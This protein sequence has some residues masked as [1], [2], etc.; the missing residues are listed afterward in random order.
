MIQELLEL[1]PL[2]HDL[3]C[4]LDVDQGLSTELVKWQANTTVSALVG[5]HGETDDQ[6]PA[7]GPLSP[8]HPGQ[9]ISLHIAGSGSTN[10]PKGFQGLGEVPHAFSLAFPMTAPCYAEAYS[11]EVRRPYTLI[12]PIIQRSATS[13][14]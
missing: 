9:S 13:T 1:K 8:M 3:R 10:L 12:R 6:V 4:V 2:G 5:C 14:L 7:D 11:Q